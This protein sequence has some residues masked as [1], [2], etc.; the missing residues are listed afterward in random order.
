MISLKARATRCRSWSGA[1][2][3]A[4][5]HAFWKQVLARDS[6]WSAAFALTMGS[7]WVAGSAI[8][9]VIHA[10]YPLDST[11]LTSAGAAPKAAW[12][13]KRAAPASVALSSG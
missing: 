7:V 13:R 9:L 12:L 2:I 6:S 1:L 3:E 8:W 4:F 11:A 10:A 5:H